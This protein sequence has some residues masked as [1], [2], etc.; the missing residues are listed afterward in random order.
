MLGNP[1]DVGHAMMLADSL[2]VHYVVFWVLAAVAAEHATST[3][4]PS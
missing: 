2:I 4:A 3:V 1:S